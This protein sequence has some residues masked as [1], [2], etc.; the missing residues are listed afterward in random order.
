MKKL[1]QKIITLRTS[2]TID[3]IV[4][5]MLGWLRGH[6]FPANIEVTGHSFKEAQLIRLLTLELSLEEHLKQLINAAMDDY[7]ACGDNVP[8]EVAIVKEEEIERIEALAKKALTYVVDLKHEIMKGRGSVLD[9]DP[10]VTSPSGEICYTLKSADNWTQAKH[11]I[12]IINYVEPVAVP[13]EDALVVERDGEGS[14]DGL[15]KT[16]TNNFYIT[17]ALL[18]EAFIEAKPDYALDLEK[19]IKSGYQGQSIPDE[20]EIKKTKLVVLMLGKYLQYR[21]MTVGTRRFARGQGDEAIMTHIEN[22]RDYKAKVWEARK[23][24]KTLSFT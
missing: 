3:E 7:S 22:A 17:F 4:A 21:S 14:R 12:S 16:V 6:N 13:V 20:E 10:D 23:V 5:K 19:M 8:Y 2:F 11:G 15:S 1:E 9:E 18:I 24:P